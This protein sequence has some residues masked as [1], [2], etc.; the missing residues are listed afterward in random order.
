MGSD[1]HGLERCL[2]VRCYRRR[3]SYRSVS[4][5]AEAF[6]IVLPERDMAG[7]RECG[8]FEEIVSSSI[9]TLRKRRECLIIRL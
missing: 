6:P 8:D 5:A 4:E 1:V 2:C 9:S 7:A 3:C